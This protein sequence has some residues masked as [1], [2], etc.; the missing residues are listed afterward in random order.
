M[1]G[2][3]RVTRTAESRSALIPAA[4][5][6]WDLRTYRRTARWHAPLLDF[7]LPRLSRLADK[8]VLWSVIATVLNQVGGRQGRRA[9][10]R[11]LFALALGSAVGNLVALVAKRKRPDIKDVPK[12]RRL[13]RLPL[14]PSFPSRHTTSA[15]AFAAGAALEKPLLAAPLVPLAAA[16][17]YSRVYTGVHYP[18]DVIAGAAL[19]SGLAFLTRRLWPVPPQARRERV[20]RPFS[21]TKDRQATAPDSPLS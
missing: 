21:W 16:V 12:L 18:S 5:Q 4:V 2:S 17:G 14:S 11:G 1:L 13:A 19:G 6:E 20:R 10:L 3:R 7:L 15:F 9:G 8:S